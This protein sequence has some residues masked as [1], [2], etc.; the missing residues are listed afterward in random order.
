MKRTERGEEEEGERREGGDVEVKRGGAAELCSSRS[1]VKAG[2]QSLIEGGG[3]ICLKK[4][5][6]LNENIQEMLKNDH[7]RIL[8]GCSSSQMAPARSHDNL[9]S[10]CHGNNAKLERGWRKRKVIYMLAGAQK[11]AVYNVK[12]EVGEWGGGHSALPVSSHV[13]TYTAQRLSPPPPTQEIYY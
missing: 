10:Y 1:Q 8:G 13:H 7:T 12:G 6:Q 3:L 9:P 2:C 5:P 11:Q 4:I